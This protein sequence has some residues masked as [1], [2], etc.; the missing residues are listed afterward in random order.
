VAAVLIQGYLRLTKRATIM[1]GHY[2]RAH[3]FKRAGKRNPLGRVIRDICRKIEGDPALE[4]RFGPPLDLALR[5]PSLRAT[6]A[7]PGPSKFLDIWR[8]WPKFK[9]YRAR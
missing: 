6:P 4:Y 8:Q 2:T 1:V 9:A 3:Q 5:G 7:A